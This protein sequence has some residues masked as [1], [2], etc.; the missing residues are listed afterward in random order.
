VKIFALRELKKI[1]FIPKALYISYKTYFDLI[2]T[3]KNIFHLKPVHYSHGRI[4]PNPIHYCPKFKEERNEHKS[5]KY[6]L[7]GQ[8]NRNIE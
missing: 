4:C 6:N 2:N 7:L 3:S 8:Y 1:V 5:A